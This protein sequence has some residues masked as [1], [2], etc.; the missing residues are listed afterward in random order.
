MRRTSGGGPHPDAHTQ[1]EERGVNIDLRGDGGYDARYVFSFLKSL[2]ITPLISVRIDSNPK[3][4]DRAR[5]VLDQMGRGGRLHEQGSGPHDENGAPG[6][7]K[8]VE[9]ACQVRVTVAGGDR[10]I[11]IQARLRE[12]GEGAP[13]AHRIRRGGHQDSSLQLQLGHRGRGCQGSPGACA[14]A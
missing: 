7:P 1:G 9:G 2:D 12:V 6:Q 4:K 5:I 3:G 14:A 11:G 10:D 8:E 13:A